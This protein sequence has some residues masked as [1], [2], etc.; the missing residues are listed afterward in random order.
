MKNTL[1]KKLRY[2]NKWRRGADTPQPDPKE[3]GQ[4]IDV[5]ADWIEDACD[6]ID[7]ATKKIKELEAKK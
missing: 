4:L 5:A 3:L 7:K 6:W 2:Y 1:S